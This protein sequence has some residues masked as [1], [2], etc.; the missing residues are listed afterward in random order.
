MIHDDEFVDKS[1][2]LL[3]VNRTLQPAMFRMQ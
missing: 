1:F 2:I 3:L